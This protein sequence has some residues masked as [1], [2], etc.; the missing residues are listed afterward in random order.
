MQTDTLIKPVRKKN[1]VKAEFLG[2]GMVYSVNYE[3]T[4]LENK[5]HNF[6]CRAGLNLVFLEAYHTFFPLSIG[7]NQYLKRHKVNIGFG[8]VPIVTEGYHF[9]KPNG[10]VSYYPKFTCLFN[11]TIGYSYEFKKGF[12]LGAQYYPTLVP[13]Y[14]GSYFET[15][16]KITVYYNPN[17]RIL[18]FPYFI[19]LNFGFKF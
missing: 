7:Y 6:Y 9:P 1:E 10:Y 13:P 11:M 8:A 12:T 15:D 3:R 14:A 18:P 19:A 17:Y 2:A 4:F 5:N 16:E